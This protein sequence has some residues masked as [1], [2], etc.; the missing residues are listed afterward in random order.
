MEMGVGCG[1]VK[2]PPFVALRCS[3]LPALCELET[4]RRGWRQLE[5]CECFEGGP[6]LFRKLFSHSLFF[7]LPEAA[8]SFRAKIKPSRGGAI[9]GGKLREGKRKEEG[10]GK[11][12]AV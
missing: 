10:K 5:A 1:W 3:P 9:E 12:F 8:W 2:V 6:G 11:P 7:F 4:E